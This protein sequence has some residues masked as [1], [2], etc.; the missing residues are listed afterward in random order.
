MQKEESKLLE[1]YF[2]FTKWNFTNPASRLSQKDVARE[3]SV[4]PHV[5]V[6]IIDQTD[7]HLTRYEKNIKRSCMNPHFSTLNLYLEPF[8]LNFP[9]PARLQP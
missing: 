7:V 3:V 9:I 4:K 5:L 1:D 2:V 6:G 8:Q